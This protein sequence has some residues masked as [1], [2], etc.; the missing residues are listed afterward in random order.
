M[1]CFAWAR[2]RC[3]LHLQGSKDRS[4]KG[5]S[6]VS[7]PCPELYTITVNLEV[8]QFLADQLSFDFIVTLLYLPGFSHILV[9]PITW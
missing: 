3:D 9:L 2:E 7:G 8:K 1:L 4:A 6:W 5:L